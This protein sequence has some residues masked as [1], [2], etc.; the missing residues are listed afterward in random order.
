MLSEKHRGSK[1]RYPLPAAGRGQNSLKGGSR[2]TN[3][4]PARL[5]HVLSRLFRL[6]FFDFLFGHARHF[7]LNHKACKAVSV[8]VKQRA[9]PEHPLAADRAFQVAKAQS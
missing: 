5:P 9:V 7:R 3:D 2:G 4:A 1:N 6:V 8:D